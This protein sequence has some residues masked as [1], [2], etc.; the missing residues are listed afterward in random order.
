MFQIS[1]INGFYKNTL[2]KKILHSISLINLDDSKLKIQF[3]ME[4]TD[5]FYVFNIDYKPY[6]YICYYSIYIEIYKIHYLFIKY[7]II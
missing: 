6:D 1:H 5:N 7:S 3:L 2:K 4:L